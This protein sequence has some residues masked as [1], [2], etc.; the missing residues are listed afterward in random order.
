MCFIEQSLQKLFK[1]K[2]HKLN[3]KLILRAIALYRTIEIEGIRAWIGF[4]RFF[5]LQTDFCHQDVKNILVSFSG[6]VEKRFFVL[7]ELTFDS[8]GGVDNFRN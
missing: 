3:G 6:K 5:K 7:I 1:P 2:I 4:F 8:H